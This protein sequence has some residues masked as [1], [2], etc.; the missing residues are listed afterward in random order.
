MD[1]SNPVGATITDNQGL[2]TINNDDATAISIDDVTVAEGNSGT[3]AFT[4]TV[5]LTNPSATDVT[6]DYT[7]TDGTAT[8]ADTDYVAASGNLTIPAGSTTAQITVNVTGDT[9]VEGDETFTVDLSNPVGATITDNQGLGTINN[10]DATAISI[11]DVSIN[12]GN[13]GTTA[14][15]FTVSLTNP[16]ATDVTVDYT[17]TD[18]TAATADSDYAAASGNLI[19]SAGSTTGQITVNVTG[20]T[21]VEG[22]ETFTV[23]L[24]NPVGATITDNQGLGTIQNDDAT[25]MSINDITIN[26]GDSG[27]TAFTFTVSL[28]IP[29]ATDVTV[30]YTTTDG[31][32]TS[33]DTDYVATSGNLTIP[34]GSTT[35]QITINVTGDTKV[36]GD[37]TY[38]VD[39]SN[40]VGATISDNQGLGT[41][42]NDD[43][44][45]ISIDD[46]SLDEGNAG[47]TAF[48]F[49]V[50]LSNP[51]ASNVS[52]DYQTNDGTATAGVDY[53]GIPVTTLT[54]LPGETSKTVTVTV[55]GDVT[56][57]VDDTFNVDLS[58]PVGA[59]ILDSQGDGI[60]RNDDGTTI[61][62]D[63]VSLAEG[64]AGTTSFSFTVSLSNPSA[65]NVTVDYQTAPGS[66]TDGVDFS[67]IGVTMLTFLPG[68][69]SKTVVVNVNGDTTVEGDET[70]TLDLSN[71]VGAAM[72]DNQG[73]GTIQNDDTATISINDIAMNEGN[74]GNTAF[75][76]T[77][78][79]TNP[80]AADVTVDYTAT[81]GTA[82]T[83]DA[84][85]TATSGTLTLPAGTTTGQIT[86]NVTGDTTVEGNETFTVD[87]SNPAGAT[88]TD[89]QGLGTINN[90]DATAISIDDVTVPE[91]DSGTTAFTFTVSLA[92]PSATD[93]TVD[94][95]T[96]DVTAA[97]ADGDYAAASG[98][99]T[100]PAGSTTAQITVNVTG[101]TKV[102][103]NETFMVDLSNSVGA[104]ISDSQ[105]LGTINND[106]STSI[107]IDDV[108]VAEG[109]AGTTAFTFT[110]SLSNPSATDVTVDY[111][112][113][114]GTS[115]TA[116]TDYTATSGTLTI[117]A[118][119]TTSQITVNVTGDTKVE[120]NET[121]TVDLSNPGGATI[122]D[123]QGLGTINNDDATTVTIDD[124]SLNEGNAGTTNFTF[125]VSLTNPS[126]T[127]VTVD[128]TTTDGTATTGDSDYAGTAGNLTI[129]AG[130]TTAPI[131]VNATG[132]TKVE[133]NETFT[134]D[135]SNPVG[136]TITDNQGLGTINND[137]A[138]TVMIDDVG[139][140]E[141]NSGTTA[142]TFT[143]SLTNPSA[144][145]VTVDY[146]TTDGTATTADADYTATSGTLTIPAGSTTAQ[147]TVNVAGDTKVEGNEAFTVDLSNPVGATISDNQGLG[148]INNDDAT[149]ISI[150]DVTVAEGNSG[151]TAFTFTVSLTNPSATDV[152]VDYTTTDGTAATLD[153]DYTSSSGT[154]TIPAGSTT[155]QV[156]V[157]VTGDTK[158]E[159]NETFTVNLSNPLGATITDNQGLGTINND[160]AATISID[161]VSINEGNSG[162]TAF[163]FTVSLTNTSATDV[164]IDYTTTDATATTADADYT[165]ASGTLT[166]PAGSTTAQITV[167]VTGDVKVEAGET[168]TV[169]LS[170]PVGATITDNQGV[171]TIQND[172]AASLSINDLSIVEGDAGT[173]VF[174]FTVTLSNPSASNVS[175]DYQTNDGTAAA[176]TD[177]TGIPVTTLTFLPG[178]T[179]KTVPA[180]VNGD[181]TVEVDE[182]FAVDLSNPSGATISDSQGVGTIR[183]DDGTTFSIDDVSLAEGNAGTTAFSFTVSL[184][185]P[186]AGIVSVDYQTSDGTASAGVDYA[187][188]GVTTLTLLPGET[189]KTVTVNGSGDVTVEADETFTVELSNPV[190]ATLADNQGLG[191][192]LND[193]STVVSIDDVSIN[194]GNSGTTAFTFTVS[195][196][197]PSATDVSVDYTTTDGS[198][199]T[200]DSD[201][202]ATS[203]TLTIPAGST[204]GQ[205]TVNVT[206]DNKVEGNET[207]TVD[208]SNPVGATITDNQGLGTINNDD[209]TA[210]SIDDVTVAEGNSGTTAFTF[211]VSL[212]NPSATDVTVDYTTTDGTAT[213]ADSDYGTESGTLTMPAGSTTAQITVNAVGDAKV[214]GNETFTVDL[215]NPVGAAITDNQGLGTINNDDAT[216]LSID[217]VTVAEGNSGTAAFIF[218]VSLTNP[219][220]SDV[221]V[222]Y[223]TTDGTATTADSDY[224]AAS[225][226]LTIPAGSTSGQITVDVTGDAKVEGNETF[227][228]GLSN[229]VG[230]TISDNQGLGTI[231]NDDAT[232][233]SIDD[234]SV[235]EGNAGTTAFT[236]TVSLTNP[237]ATDVTVDYTTVDGTATT[238]DADY[239]AAAGML[240]IPA[241]SLSNAITVNV[242]GDATV[243][244]DE[245]FTM[246][247]SNPS[248]ATI[249]D[250]Q[251]VG[252][253]RNDDGTT[254]S[255]D[256][257][258]LAEGN[259]GTT[260][261]NFTVALSNPSAG[262]V[263]VDYQTTDGTAT[264][265]VDYTAIPATSLTFLP[266]E[267]SKTVTV[268]V[269]GDVTV[270]ADE[271]FTLDLSN[272][273]GAT[274][275]DSQGS[276]TI[277]NDDAATISI[278]DI[279]INEGNS[280][281][282]AF[283]F[284]VSLTNPSTSDVTVDYTT[285]DGTATTADSDYSATSGTLTIPVGSTT[286]AITVNAIGDA[287]VESDET[288]TLD[289]SNPSGATVSDNQG[290]GTIGNDDSG[291]DGTVT[292]T[293]FSRPGDTLDVEVVDADLNTDGA[294]VESVV[295][296][297]VNDMTGEGEPLTLTETGPD[298][299]LFSAT[300]ATTF[301][302]VAGAPNDGSFNT[303][304]G[305][306]ITVTYNDTL[307][308]TNG[309]ATLTDVDTVQGGVDGV[310]T[311]TPTSF[312]GDTLTI[313]VTDADLDV[314]ATAAESVMVDV[315]NDMTGELEQVT[316]TE[317]GPST[318]IFSGSLPTTF[319]TSAGTD[320][321]GVLNTQ[322][323]DTV[324]V[325]Y[326]DNLTASGGSAVRTDTDV[327]QGLAA[328]EGYAWIDGNGN[329]FF[330]GTE[331]PLNGWTVEIVKG[332]VLLATTSVAADGSYSVNN[333]VPDTGYSVVLRHPETNV[334]WE[335]LDG[336][337]LPAGTTVID[338][339]LPVDPSGIVYDAQARTPLT[340]VTLT[341]MNSSGVPVANSCLGAGQQGQVTGSDGA[342]RFDVALG[343]DPSCASDDV[344][345]I[346]WSAPSG[347]VSAPSTE[348]P[349]LSGPFDPTGLPNPVQIVPTFSVPAMGDSTDY[350]LSFQL[351]SGDPD[352]INNHLP[353]DPLVPNGFS[354]RT[355]KTADRSRATLG[356]M[357]RYRVTLE[358]ITLNNVDLLDVTL[359]DTI[360]AGFS[361][362]KESARLD[363]EETG[364]TVTGA[365]PV[366]F[367]GI[368]IPAGETVTL[369]YVLR[370]GS[371]VVP[372]GYVNSA[373]PFSGGTQIGNRAQATVEITSDPDFE[374][375]TIIGKVFNDRNGD[376]WQDPGEEGIPGV[377]L[378]TVSGLVVETDAY[379][380]YHLAG[381]EGGRFDRG[382]N[383]ILKVD[384]ST[385]PDGTVFTT[386]NPRVKRIT[387]GLLNRFDFGV[388]RP[389]QEPCC[390]SIE[391][392]LGEIF[393]ERGS[394]K[395]RT[396]YMPLIGDLADRL[397]EHGGGTLYIQGH[398]ETADE[399]VH[400]RDRT[401]S[402]I[403][404]LHTLKN[405]FGKR[406]ASLSRSQRAELDRLAQQWRAI[407]DIRIEVVGHTDNVPIAPANRTEF[408]DNHA[409]SEARAGSVARY[410]RERLG[411]TPDRLTARG[412][413]PNEPVASNETPEGRALN[414]R[415]ELY[416]RGAGA[417]DA[418]L[419]T[420]E[421]E[422][423]PEAPDLSQRRA[424][425]IY[426]AL[427]G[428][429]G[430]ELMRQIRIEIRREAESA[431]PGALQE[432]QASRRESKAKDVSWKTGFSRAVAALSEFLIPSACAEEPS[433]D[434]CTIDHCRTADGYV[435]EIITPES[436]TKPEVT[437][438]TAVRRSSRRVDLSG[439][440]VVEVPGGGRLWATEDPSVVDPR[441]A[442]AGPETLPV[443][444]GRIT[445]TAAFWGYSNYAV[446]IHRLEVLI[447]RAED[448]DR[449]APIAKIRMPR[450]SLMHAMWNGEVS[451]Q[452][453]LRAGDELVYL[454]RAYDA[455]GRVDETRPRTVQ[456]VHASAFRG[457]QDRTAAAVTPLR[458]IGPRLTLEENLRGSAPLSG[459]LL[460]LEPPAPEV[461][462]VSKSKVYT[463][464]PRFGRRKAE[465]RAEDRAALSR[466]A[467]EWQGVEKI[468]VQ[469]VGHT[470]D[471]PIAPGN[472]DEFADNHV[473]SEAR[474]RSVAR[475]LQQLLRLSS[476][477]IFVDGR[478]PDE[479]V[480]SNKT[481]AGRARNRRVE[482]SIRGEERV[483]EVQERGPK[484]TLLDT[485]LGLEVPA[486]VGLA[487][488]EEALA[489]LVT[490]QSAAMTPDFDDGTLIPGHALGS[491][492]GRSDLVRQNIP[493]HGSRVR[494]HGQ[495]LGGGYALMINGEEIPV[496]T[497]GEF[498]V[499]YMMPVGTHEF[500]VTLLTAD[501]AVAC[502][503]TLTADVTGK[504]MF[505][506]GLAD[507]TVSGNH[508]SGSVE[509]LAA[510]DRYD[511]DILVEGR[512]A[513][514]LKGKVR[515]KYL[516]T[517]Q[518]DS[519]EEELKNVLRHLHRKDPRSLFRRLDPDRYY[520]VYGDDS[521]TLQDVD[522][523][524]RLYL[525]IDWDKSRVL[526]GDYNTGLT[527]NEF[528]Q[529]NRSLYGAQVSHESTGTTALDEARTQGR[530]FVSEAQ[531]V[532]GHA[533]FLGTG[534]SLYYLKHTDIAPGSEKVRVEV[535]D[536]DS[537]RVVQNNTLEQGAD[538]D[539]DEL[540]GRIIL[541][542][543]LLQVARQAAPSLV[544]DV[545]L[546]GNEVV[547]LVDYE[548]VPDSF[549]AED[550]T[551]G[552]RARQWVTDH[553][554]IGAT[555][556]DENRGGEDYTL[557]GA[558]VTLKAGRG[559]Y[560]KVEY[561]ETEA[562]QADVWHSDD[563]G[564]SFTKRNPPA[565]AET[566][567]SAVGVEARVN[568]T[569][570]T[571]GRREGAAAAWWKDR[572]AGF[573][574]ARV[575]DG[576]GSEEYGGEV[577][578]QLDEN[579]SIASRGTVLNRDGQSRDTT[580]GIQA[581]YRGGEKTTLGLEVRYVSDAPD[582]GAEKEAV[583]G[584]V[585]LGYDVTERVNVYGIAQATVDKNDAYEDNDLYTVGVDTQW[586]ERLSVKAEASYGDRGRSLLL[587]TDY[588]ITDCHQVYTSYT[589][590]TDRTDR[591]EYGI[592]TLGERIGLSNQL[593]V[594][595]ENQFRHSDRQA[596]IA[597]VFGLDFDATKHW[598]LGASFQSS[599]LDDNTDDGIERDAGTLSALYRRGQTR[600]SSK[601]EYR[602]DRG[603]ER[604]RQ[605]LTTNLLNYKWT[606]DY[607]WLGKLS[608]S[609]TEDAL[610]ALG[611]ARFAEAALGL[612][613]RPVHHDRFNLLGRY[614]FL[615]DLPSL[616]QE[617]IGT[618]QR[619][620]VLSVEGLY[621]L[622]R[623]WD[624][625]GK[626]ASR[627]G[628]LRVDR[629]RGDWFRAQTNFAALRGNYHL[630]QHWDA[631]LEYRWLNV[632]EAEST[633]QGFLAG[634]SRHIG[635][636]YK[637]GLGYNFTD[638][639]DDL[640]ELDYDFD[641]WFINA[642]GKY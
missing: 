298:T 326:M 155:G 341:L 61:S 48:D 188:I 33:A 627:I 554:G 250:N 236:F 516:I 415:I 552:G 78:S 157:N 177:Y 465:L 394:D 167:N 62:V 201:Y 168:F 356:E 271:G 569:E 576:Q 4:F 403:P 449:L 162:T 331:S 232:A 412:K 538:Y 604:R 476:D 387:Q 149:T 543:P 17:T 603:S 2:G 135:L 71:P 458:G 560:V 565:M 541:T 141:G 301:G 460:V 318:G 311:I 166:I 295:V 385:L 350:Y 18:G 591:D 540:Q 222:D 391:V 290:L 478:G 608:L 100:I 325:T 568:F 279:S 195:L 635:E 144:A 234:V 172:D 328:I 131:T 335:R 338:Q 130:S 337:T 107:S 558:D 402:G 244:V 264:G 566:E 320:N 360:P 91:G 408:A 380:R 572:D 372:G 327:V 178:E 143:V 10:D 252:T 275:A 414:R 611:D 502:S 470:S 593:R 203:G 457:T 357:V 368:D 344:Y 292:I 582:M 345:A 349:P 291:N 63:D 12:E 83:A 557:Q 249:S 561:A 36:E 82:T 190:G 259:A 614:T 498:A 247:L 132:D 256:D 156:T 89:N 392:K 467:E 104:T 389:D 464:T 183:N 213:T 596:G 559:T 371:G 66:A 101:D 170:N 111:T 329:D 136:A 619:S 229:P 24:S 96:T 430:E 567:G 606:Q 196:T 215:S 586:N 103:G 208:L 579:F 81:D 428:L 199:T 109:N 191:T 152:T 503:R 388:R 163:T 212:T 173:T 310:V 463:L 126:A 257:V 115:T 228:V 581:D 165:A 198:A 404:A 1:L 142:F 523:Q 19:I 486:D 432:P 496:N 52:V 482:L 288:F 462:I 528:A 336:V 381:I 38:T 440:F 383:F 521:T 459:N 532:L 374:Q 99:L 51:S 182:T 278:D 113:T 254:L 269:T 223:T 26:E 359:V 421:K 530:L 235:N 70:F 42:Q 471:V 580:F 524:G 65:S 306:T 59:T 120:G 588:R 314:N 9:K 397:R 617:G 245:S 578:L 468:H 629:N 332:A 436:Q 323:S 584:A 437:G 400:D 361:Y 286:A 302:T 333:L 281:T 605:W 536:R 570:V 379:G 340:G 5:S 20:D 393:F 550:V 563:G 343:A 303:Q 160:D 346:V 225:G 277:Q 27:T 497:D 287:A 85:Y 159:G 517:A 283:T 308:S 180:N 206:G 461:V 324:T 102:E 242:N 640:T 598:S 492:Y 193:D 506:V 595:H 267:T 265:G 479:P 511:E 47:S 355:V 438:S 145:D 74:S 274:I 485:E 138:A 451:G 456:L 219:S 54:F 97:T 23:D 628:E 205:I 434:A 87:L 636:H 369:T 153:S 90:D 509:P 493:I 618:D 186:S 210:I 317:T 384:P 512:L 491:I 447:Y 501:E 94:Y 43:A 322:G 351:A 276:G 549:E 3:T 184:S 248:G 241:G 150:D 255:V 452:R 514:Y 313:T 442:V 450:R 444:D 527:G 312:P 176:G 533:E 454:L 446:F 390:E 39:L 562:A 139:I 192:I 548:Y 266:G 309:T 273:S 537:Q 72:A 539:I 185:N 626:V 370:I 169:D 233:I 480:A 140:N 583:L 473:L 526:W 220:A 40:P 616:A 270:E 118:G 330:D 64:N 204:T 573:S 545:P 200:G 57:E 642:I 376:G 513:F 37:E 587:G 630:I 137:D 22:D 76:F 423:G 123:N 488:A 214:E 67:G 46:V 386:E 439:R 128:Y 258:S 477:A 515:G 637:L 262:N 11:D 8:T 547:L 68:E 171:G 377:R 134:V 352:I 58:S 260:A 239:A 69:T 418:L 75:M 363:G 534:G 445:E 227:T 535:R 455:A 73:S 419:S 574:T 154:L 25:S 375:T 510:D 453:K 631:L 494:I 373:A 435:V 342:Y 305:D 625:G 7:S 92:N 217:D 175:V 472:R 481:A 634:L 80:S 31:T 133:G 32:A 297:L 49:T 427:K 474:A 106:D 469:A 282:T 285:T 639:S 289:L 112:T 592:F 405:S 55:N 553:I 487:A 433:G 60:I 116:D 615:Y 41:I 624:L 483:H 367:G 86:V 505:L 620:H 441:L 221:T 95:T 508:I 602:R 315:L 622:N 253:I 187:A 613:Y 127:E 641:G 411:L 117:S 420:A 197:N 520:P 589:F 226:T 15:T 280:G 348:I 218:T 585:K 147:I 571:D 347:Y 98:T 300:V 466:I 209:A 382:R 632:D 294:I 121:F 93:V 600:L 500:G 507:V 601:L 114:D 610:D 489:G 164:T 224:T 161:D 238:V 555:Y 362:V 189:S 519:E 79:L 53:A 21:K 353:L 158:V 525:R 304:A 499:E 410:L 416:I 409:L 307:T 365:R 398:R 202:A 590:L 424:R 6:V 531:T 321:D 431:G 633:R 504:H 417:K 34:A 108:A 609:R 623:F 148:T 429:L 364:V 124:I 243:E 443:S 518:M 14:F 378:A 395:I 542:R 599:R 251:G 237:S 179:S 406:K 607:T 621:R 50:T 146:T 556:V 211:T 299:G 13:S 575:P 407:S 316:L 77:V 425:K 293:E 334:V 354:V 230:A 296:A 125:T 181:V 399:R 263:T 495:E 35:A 551:V 358:N 475:Y 30:D 490:A 129:P 522:S 174:S 366:R 594:Y 422:A 28:T 216:G 16:S 319:G 564:L 484:M 151:T 84:D 426:E 122:S 268:N 29:S 546:D 44:A 284:T 105:G 261:F 413:G 246:D 119:S 56:V 529:Y 401:D 88:I 597:H 577:L 544:K 240:T 339:N 396:E 207:F 231:N 448:S 45:T 612:A 272:P 110:V 638:F 194:E